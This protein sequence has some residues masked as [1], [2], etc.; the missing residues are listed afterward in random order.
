[1]I[2]RS[3]RQA[4]ERLL[5]ETVAHHS[6]AE[7]VTAQF[8]IDGLPGSTGRIAE[9]DLNRASD[10]MARLR[11]VALERG[12]VVDFTGIAIGEQVAGR[13]SLELPARQVGAELW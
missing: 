2:A 6:H 4:A 8:E 12:R 5:A 13:I 3:V 7:P 9:R 11:N 10:V 1:V